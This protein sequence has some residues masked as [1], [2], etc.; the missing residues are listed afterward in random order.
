MQRMHI[1]APSPL[2]WLTGLSG[3]G[4]TTVATALKA[5][6]RRQDYATALLD[7]DEL[8]AGLCRDLGFSAADRTENTRRVGEVAKLF[9]ETGIVTLVALIS[10][11]AEDRKS[12]RDLIGPDFIEVFVD[13]PLAICERR[14][15]KGLYAKVRDG[16]NALM[17]G[18]G[19]PY[20]PPEKP[21]IRLDGTG[22]LSVED[23]VDLLMGYLRHRG[24]FA[25]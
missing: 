8:R 17:S 6:L 21:E 4:K 20:E 12:V 2:I 22:T 10:P 7:G 3:A 1:I 5:R 19:S 18:I 11:F 13:T 9:Q 24:Y 14:D 15:P 23:Q 25:I 16:T